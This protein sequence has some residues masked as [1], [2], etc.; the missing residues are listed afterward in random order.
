MFDVAFFHTRL[1]AKTVLYTN[2][3]ENIY[4]YILSLAHSK[5]P[6]LRLDIL[7]VRTRIVL[8]YPR[9]SFI[10]FSRITVTVIKRKRRRKI[11]LTSCELIKF[12]VGLVRKV[13][14]D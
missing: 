10:L 6:F 2:V 14:G 5:E 12:L 1:D 4:I 8:I 13:N 7:C 3:I 11:L 9:K